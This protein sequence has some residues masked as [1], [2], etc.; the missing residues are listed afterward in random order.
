MFGP[1]RVAEADIRREHVRQGLHGDRVQPGG[2]RLRDSHVIFELLQQR[3]AVEVVMWQ[4]QRAV[5]VGRHETSRATLA[6]SATPTTAKPDGTRFATSRRGVLESADFSEEARTWSG[7][8]HAG[9]SNRHG[10]LARD[11]GN[12]SK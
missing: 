10:K 9:R 5:W 2:S 7:R 8:R 6:V 12:S 3:G 4:I 1:G 11:V